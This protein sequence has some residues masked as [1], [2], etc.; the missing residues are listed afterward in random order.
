MKI[1]NK[2]TPLLFNRRKTSIEKNKSVE[3]EMSST[4]TDFIKSCPDLSSF[5]K[6]KPMVY[7]FE[8]DEMNE[9]LLSDTPHSTPLP[10]TH[11]YPLV[12]PIHETTTEYSSDRDYQL[13]T[14]S[15]T[16]V[17]DKSLG[18]NKSDSNNFN[19]NLPG[20]SLSLSLDLNSRS[21]EKHKEWLNCMIDDAF[22][23]S[24]GH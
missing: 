23:Q 8:D 10:G 4:K 14:D 15:K 16:N 5:S 2:F 22:E 9:S 6:R 13:Q 19:F 11:S 17:R 21:L 7:R 12:L 20:A 24:K 1:F 18:N 3:E